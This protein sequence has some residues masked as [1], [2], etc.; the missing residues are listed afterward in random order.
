MLDTPHYQRVESA[1]SGAPWI[2]L[3]HGVSQNARL[4]DQQVALLKSAYRLLL[5]DLP[6]H[7][8]SSHLPG[9]Y[10]LQEYAASIQSALG[11]AGIG[12]CHFWGTHLGAGAG[13]LLACQEPRL[14]RTLVLESPVFPGRVL[15]CVSELLTRLSEVARTRGMDAARD[16]WWHEGAWFDVM[17]FRPRECRALEHREMIAS[18]AGAPWLDAGLVARPIAP[19]EPHASSLQI[20]T[21]IINGEHD[22]PDFLAAAAALHEILP[23][24][25]RQSIPQAGGFPLWEFPETVTGLAR[26]F[27]AL[28]DPS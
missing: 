16:M 3:V 26:D 2:V 9:P 4:F 6:G 13:L 14:F 19:I 12:G 24:C 21:L 1:P 17:R 22:L 7:G 5:I 27:L 20:P 8:A 23:R 25:R 10:G 15:P 18:F 28:H 11:D